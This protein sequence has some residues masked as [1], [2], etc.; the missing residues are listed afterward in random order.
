MLDEKLY[1]LMEIYLNLILLQRGGIQTKILLFD[2]GKKIIEAK[3]TI[4]EILEP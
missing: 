2:M 4:R 3:P 1:P